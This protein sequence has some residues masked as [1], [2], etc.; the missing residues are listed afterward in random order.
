MTN[1]ENMISMPW[2]SL[3][4]TMEKPKR[5]IIKYMKTKD[6]QTQM[7]KMRSTLILIKELKMTM[8]MMMVMIIA[9]VQCEKIS[10]NA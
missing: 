8:M 7:N 6:E 3:V 4:G 1:N 5:Q 9:V 10:Q 2:R